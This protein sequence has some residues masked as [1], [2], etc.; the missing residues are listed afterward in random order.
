MSGRPYRSN[1][2]FSG[3]AVTVSPT[4]ANSGPSPRSNIVATSSSITMLRTFWR[5]I[6]EL[7]F[8]SNASF[9]VRIVCPAFTPS[10]KNG[11]SRTPAKTRRPLVSPPRS[12]FT[13]NEATCPVAV[14]HE[15]SC[16]LPTS[17]FTGAAKRQLKMYSFSLTANSDPG[18]LEVIA[19]GRRRTRYSTASEKSAD[20]PANG[21]TFSTRIR[22]PDRWGLGNANISVMST[23]GSAS[24]LGEDPWSDIGR[25]LSECRFIAVRV[26][27]FK[28]CHGGVR[29]ICQSRCRSSGQI[30]PLSALRWPGSTPS[31]AGRSSSNGGTRE[32]LT[33]HAPE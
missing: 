21:N 2:T 13:R 5:N 17:R 16:T 9:R 1:G 10:K 20:I 29:N 26:A 18:P 11:S 24:A 32:G 25:Y 3:P 7:P 28:I 19:I 6:V 15:P 33:I 31:R 30:P 4:M 23:T 8:A 12:S 22:V 14:A 27:T